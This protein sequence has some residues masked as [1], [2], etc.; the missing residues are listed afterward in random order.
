MLYSPV[1]NTNKFMSGFYKSMLRM[2]IFTHKNVFTAV[3]FHLIPVVVIFK[4]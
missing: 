4:I 3:F 2:T 1:V